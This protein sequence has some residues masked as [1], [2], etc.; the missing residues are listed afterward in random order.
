MYF[1]FISNYHR[2]FQIPVFIVLMVLLFIITSCASSGSSTTK[3]FGSFKVTETV[4]AKDIKNVNGQGV[5]IN[6]TKSFTTDDDTVVSH[7]RFINLTGIH[8]LRWEWYTPDM[9]LYQKTNNY[10]IKTSGNTFAKQGSATHKI[11][12]KGAKPE[13]LPGRWKVKFYLDD[14]MI[15]STSFDIEK[16]EKKPVQEISKIPDIDFGNYHALVIGNQEY[17]YMTNLKSSEKDALEVTRLL[18]DTYGFEVKSLIDATRSD[19]LTA[20]IQ[21]RRELDNTDNLL[22]YYAGHGWLDDDADEGYW[23]PVDA[24][25]DNYQNWISNSTITS[26]LKA[27]EA[28]HVL[29]VA[30]SCYSGKLVRGIRVQIKTHSYLQTMANK[31]VRSVLCSGGLEPV[32]DAGGKEGHSVFASAFLDILRDNQAVIDTTEVFSKLRRPVLLNSEQTPEYSDIK[33]AGH[34]GG[35]FLFVRQNP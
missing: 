18:R 1:S 27:I 7:I 6:T 9:T 14:S 3:K 15:A 13:T 30:D 32:Y 19:I 20:L 23:L 17:M 16:L 33:K 11:P 8:N 28:K 29:V 21:Y 5:P 26:Q 34:E 24:Q 2:S 35:D 22:I 12:I 31:R 25:L 10:P 4:L